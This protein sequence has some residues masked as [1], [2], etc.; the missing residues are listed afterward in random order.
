[1]FS[2]VKWKARNHKWS[3]F[4]ATIITAISSAFHRANPDGA[5]GASIDVRTMVL[6]VGDR[7]Q[8]KKARSYGTINE[9]KAQG[10][11]R[12]SY[13]VEWDDQETTVGVSPAGHYVF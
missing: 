10:N 12:R 3:N 4:I 5:S 6:K 1:M 9:V 11:K 2:G 13:T 8:H 7:V